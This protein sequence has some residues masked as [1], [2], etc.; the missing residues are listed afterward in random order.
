MDQVLG[1]VRINDLQTGA[2]GVRPVSSMP[3]QKGDPMAKVGRCGSLM[4]DI[5]AK[6]VFF[7]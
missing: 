1:V 2:M 5:K 6:G 4:P 3:V 7:I